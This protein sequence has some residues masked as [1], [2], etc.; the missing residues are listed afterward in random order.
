MI[1]R[2]VQ[3]RAALSGSGLRHV[4]LSFVVDE[5]DFHV[6]SSSGCIPD[7]VNPVEAVPVASL[8]DAAPGEDASAMLFSRERRGLT[9]ERCGIFCS[10]LSVAM[11]TVRIGVEDTARSVIYASLPDETGLVL[12][13]H[14]LV[15]V[16][17]ERSVV[18][19]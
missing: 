17:D 11:C 5:D 4:F 9:V 7:N 14:S 8:A 6:D 13:S 18:C 10:A 15:G 16:Q 2:G 1:L 19:E 12:H 3:G